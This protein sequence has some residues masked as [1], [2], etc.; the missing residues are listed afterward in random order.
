MGRLTLPAATAEKILFGPISIHQEKRKPPVATQ[1][2][3]TGGFRQ[4]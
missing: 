1:R 2:A 3:T 4:F